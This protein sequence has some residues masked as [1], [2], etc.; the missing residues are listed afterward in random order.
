[1]SI[2]DALILVS[3]CGAKIWY[4]D[5]KDIWRAMKIEI[6]GGICIWKLR[7]CFL[8]SPLEG[9]VERDSRKWLMW[10]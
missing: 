7:E 9:H 6:I 8:F 4:E 5:I 10:V 3:W 2:Y 1:M